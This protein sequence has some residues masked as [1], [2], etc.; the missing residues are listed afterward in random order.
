MNKRINKT[1]DKWWTALREDLQTQVTEAPTMTAQA[2]LH[3]LWK[4]SPLILKE[5]DYQNVSVQ[6]IS[7][8]SMNVV[9]QTCK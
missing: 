5:S 7:Y 8:P 6:K 2:I 4:K 1:I 9:P 3:H